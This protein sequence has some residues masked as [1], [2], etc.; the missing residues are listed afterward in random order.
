MSIQGPYDSVEKMLQVRLRIIFMEG[1]LS[2][3]GDS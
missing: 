1:E 3:I 2:V